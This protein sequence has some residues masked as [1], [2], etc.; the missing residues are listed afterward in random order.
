MFIVL[1]SIPIITFTYSLLW[2]P[3]VSLRRTY[4]LRDFTL[5]DVWQDLHRS[6]KFVENMTTC[7]HTR[8]QRHSHLSD[9]LSFSH[10]S[11]FY[12]VRKIN[13]SIAVHVAQQPCRKPI[14]L[15]SHSDVRYRGIL[16]GI[17]PVAST[18]QLSNGMLAWNIPIFILTELLPLVY[19]MGT[20]SRRCG[21]FF[22]HAET[23]NS[24]T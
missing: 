7:Q 15:I 14:S 24:R 8:R 22:C 23:S 12:W 6:W 3:E 17:D 2:I 4:F 9:L 21:F 19:S 10:G 11:Q 20:E 5:L 18:I 13:G 1:S 16:A